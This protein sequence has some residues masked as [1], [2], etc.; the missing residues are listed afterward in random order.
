ML[1]PQPEL[2]YFSAYA[3]STNNF[4]VEITGELG[5]TAAEGG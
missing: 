5:Q 1:V 4:V 3:S 2:D